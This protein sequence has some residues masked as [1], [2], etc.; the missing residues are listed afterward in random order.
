M[1]TWEDVGTL[2]GRL[3]EVEARTSARG[4]REWR[5]RNRLFAW[6]RPSRPADL[7]SL[8]PSAPDG[9]P[10]AARVPD[11]VAKEALVADASEVYLTTPHFDGY[12]IVLVRLEAIPDDELEELLVEA[13]LDRAPARLAT[14]YLDEHGG[15]RG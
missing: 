4:H 7:A 6:E 13:W 15:L 11:R 5:V 8:G 1:A 3:P 12:P 14:R 2:T 10:L 9:P